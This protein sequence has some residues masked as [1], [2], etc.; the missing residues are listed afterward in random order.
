MRYL[1]TD[2]FNSIWHVVFG[3]M[4]VYIPLLIPLFLI[5][6]IRQGKP[7][8]FIDVCEFAIGY[9]LLKLGLNVRPIKG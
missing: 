5:Y 3:C 4:A 1:F 2:G 6:Q 9:C 7:N 8:D